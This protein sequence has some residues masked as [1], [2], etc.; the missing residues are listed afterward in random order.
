MRL[1]DLQHYDNS[2]YRPGGS[3]FKRAL[4]M[5][6]GQPV[7]SSAWLPGSELRVRLLRAF[8]ARIGARVVIKPAVRVKYPWHLEIGDDCW[9]GEDCWIDNLTTVRLGCN[10]CISQGAY[11]CTGNHDWSDPHFGLRV[12]P[13][14]LGEGSWA[15]ARSLL[16]PGTVLG[17]YAVAAA[18]AVVRGTIP[19]FEVHAGNPAQFVKLRAIRER[20]RNVHEVVRS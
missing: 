8:G 17:S 10:V 20:V 9:I 13:I 19:D 4:W 6:L 3:V 14:E 1:V 11:F 16:M 7:L 15:G 2:W 5:L 18:G 12:E